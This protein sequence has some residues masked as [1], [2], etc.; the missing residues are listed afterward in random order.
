ML[1]VS[2]KGNAAIFVAALFFV[3]GCGAIRGK[4]D[5]GDFFR[6]SQSRQSSLVSN[7]RKYDYP[8][9]ELA[10]NV[11]LRTRINSWRLNKLVEFD[12]KQ[13]VPEWSGLSHVSNNV[14]YAVSDRRGVLNRITVDINS[15]GNGKLFADDAILL[16]GAKDLEACAY[17]YLRGTIWV[18]D[19]DG[20][21]VME[22]D[23]KSGEMLS[24]LILPK[25]YLLCRAN[26]SI[27]AISMSRDGLSLW[28]VNED[29]ATCDGPPGNSKRGGI[30][31]ISLFI[32]RD[33]LDEWRCGGMW[34]YRAERLHGDDYKL[35]AVSGASAI[36]VLPDGNV[37]ILERE[38]SGAPVPSFRA[39]IYAVDVSEATDVRHVDNLDGAKVKFAKKKRLFSENTILAMYEA[40]AV[41]PSNDTDG[42][43]QLVLLSDGGY[44]AWEKAMIFSLY[45]ER[46]QK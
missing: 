6:E 1:S 24:E 5:L 29:A 9:A 28:V 40:M 35:M 42:K 22:Y 41:S 20:P 38:F 3:A 13:G 14:F 44:P 18:A 37:I 2:E 27:E 46:L 33:A 15:R 31:R 16:K 11:V 7:I 39:R 4:F 43:C 12:R 10:S 23:V 45:K 19:E 32:R 34:A 25:Q 36:E 26:R 30:L 21:R 17:D 8:Y